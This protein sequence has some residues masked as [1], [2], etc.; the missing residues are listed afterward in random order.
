M[1]GLAPKAMLDPLCTCGNTKD[2]LETLGYNDLNI[3]FIL[4]ISKIT[5]YH[6]EIKVE[7]NFRPAHDDVLHKHFFLKQII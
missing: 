7:Y 5:L 6:I 2:T 4:V 3:R 1:R